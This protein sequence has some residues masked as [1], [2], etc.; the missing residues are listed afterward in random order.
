MTTFPGLEGGILPPFK[1][2]RPRPEEM[3]PYLMGLDSFCT[4]FGATSHRKI[5]YWD[6]LAT[7][8]SFTRQ[9]YR[10]ANNG[11]LEVL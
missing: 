4:D 1:G 6:Y 3:S 5:F 9:D 11:F 10:M 2:D 7:A 8:R